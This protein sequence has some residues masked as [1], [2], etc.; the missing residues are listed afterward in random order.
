MHEREFDHAQVLPDAAVHTTDIAPGHSN[1]A[2]QLVAPTKP[3]VSGLLQRK[4]RDASGVT[5]GAE[6]AVASA[7][8]GSGDPLPEP[9]MRKFESSLG[10]DLS[11][12][13][14]HTGAESQAAATSVG[15]R[16]YT[17]GQDIHFGA[18]QY[19]PSSG[20]GQHLLAHEVAH[21]V[22]QLGGAP[23]RQNKLEVS[24]AQDHA[25][26][27]A[28]RAAD[29][30]VAGVPASVGSATLGVAAKVFRDQDP[31]TAAIESAGDEAE[32][33]ER[34]APLLVDSISVK[35]DKS[36]VAEIIADID[37]HTPI[38]QDA[39]KQHDDLEDRFAPLATNTAT[40]AN[41]SVF[42]EK[43][44]VSS[45]D[46]TAFA[47]QYR[48][49]YADYQRLTAEAHAH[50]T[51]IGVQGDGLGT[52]GDGIGKS[53]GLA[54]ATAQAGLE[55]FRAARTNLNTAAKKMDGQFKVFRGAANLLQ[56]AIY[57]AKAA[58]A[59]AKGKDAA[60]KLLAVKQEI[61]ATAGGVAKVIKTCSAV[62]G[63]AGGGGATNA[64]AAPRETG[65]TV[66]V[67]P[68]ISGLRRGG[69]VQVD[70][71]ETSRRA[72]LKAMGTDAASVAGVDLAPDKMAES[73]VKVLGEHANKDKI[74]G[75][76]AQIVKAAADE[77]SFNAAGDASNF[78][79]YQEQM[80]GAAQQLSLLIETFTTAKKEMADAGKALMAELNKQGKKGKDQAK[81]VLF[82]TDADRFLAQVTNAISVGENQ[83]TNLK[84]AAQ[85]RK[86]LRGTTAAIE[87]GTDSQT[88][89]YF[90]CH[91]TT[92]PGRLWGTNTT[93]KLD[94]VD[95]TFQD[96]G[97]FGANDIN[98]GGAGTVEGTGSANDEVATR[99]QTLK[100][101]KQQVAALQSKLQGALGLGGPGLNA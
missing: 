40:R 72:L 55:R 77:S 96:S 92:V 83:Q 90:R 41:L 38:I 99:I 25:E 79:G 24:S 81:A 19:D 13:R 36:R 89:Y 5:E 52:V 66:D 88:Q 20:A 27:E 26:L 33:R 49:A 61:E 35:A 74:A 82:L 100:N 60:T 8:S 29:A 31:G 3:V 23:T 87:G 91:K 97:G 30:M 80:N 68:G 18:G 16:A 86:A 93:Y 21:T 84:Q 95:V 46:T 32:A 69:T 17:I 39:E 76:Q 101:A 43:L 44:D 70:P 4:T 71:E 53:S 11:S 85:D 50:L 1:R 14:I 10:A 9:I 7:S 57:K 47:A 94:K 73:L 54:L 42:D 2:A 63:L 28:D 34:K 22:Q 37:K 62:A 67:E 78:V 45:V 98:Q 64:L 48:I 65:G 12:V 75:L 15:A 6:Q 58:A 56:G 59:S 51:Q